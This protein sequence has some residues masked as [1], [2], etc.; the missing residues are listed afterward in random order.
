M[1]GSRSTLPLILL[2]ALSAGCI[3]SSSD[4]A[5]GSSA[6]AAAEAAG[7]SPVMDRHLDQDELEAGSVP[8]TEILDHG[9][10]L[11]AANFNELDGAGRP[12]TTGTGGTRE[13]HSM[14][15]NFNRISAPDANSCAGCHN[16]PR[17]GGG[18]DNV[19]NVFVL[20]QRLPFVNFDGEAGDD[21]QNQ[22]LDTVANERNT[23][24]MF[25]SGYVELLARE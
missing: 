6:T 24:G 18:G 11:F 2:L 13:A 22:D 1:N 16:S 10:K 20:G 25:G 23:L 21:H 19:A 5:P 3:E 9:E 12:E 7:E 8:L 15:E 17:I 4:P 14:P